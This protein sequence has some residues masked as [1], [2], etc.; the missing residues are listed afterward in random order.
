MHSGSST[1]PTPRTTLRCESGV[2]S[3]D[4]TPTSSTAGIHHGAFH[5]SPDPLSHTISTLISPFNMQATKPPCYG[6]TADDIESWLRQNVQVGTTV[7]VRNTQAGLLHYV[8]AKVVRLSK[9]RFEIQQDMNFGLGTGGSSFYYTGKNCWHPKGQTR[10]VIPTSE[11]QL[12][13]GPPGALG[14]SYGPFTV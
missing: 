3:R 14:L 2:R 5:A 10:L 13:F 7:A 9:G 4:C 12:A 8:P 11:V 1:W 6:Q